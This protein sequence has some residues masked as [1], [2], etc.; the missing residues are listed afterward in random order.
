M[1]IRDRFP[2]FGI[3]GTGNMWIVKP[4][5]SSRGRGIRI[6]DSLREIMDYVSSKG[7]QYVVQKYIE[8]PM[9]I[10]GRKFDIRQWVLVTSW[11]PITVWMYHECYVRLG[12]VEYQRHEFSNTFMH[13]T[14]N[15][16][17]KNFKRGI[18]EIQGNMWE[19]K[20]FIEHLKEKYGKDLFG[21]RIQPGIK[22]II[23][24]SLKS[25]QDTVINRRNSV[26]LYGYD[27]MVDDG[28]TPWL[29]EINSSPAMDY[30]TVRVC[31]S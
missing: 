29:I 10:K 26:E 24:W 18:Q 16:I 8:N 30:S 6:F 15:C 20:T 3:N 19:Q 27:F 28:G 21:E 13:L 23:E 11:N 25:A 5:G 31:K 7:Q 9:L 4:I 2:Q 17:T 1:C 12:A 14:N 22:K